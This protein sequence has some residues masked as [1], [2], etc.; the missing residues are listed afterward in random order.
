MIL[1][2]YVMCRGKKKKVEDLSPTSGYKVDVKCSECEKVRSVHYRS[3]C[4]AG[5]TICQKC[6]AKIKMGKTLPIGKEFNRLTV[7]KPSKKSGY[8]IFLCKCGNVKE[9]DNNNVIIGHTTSCGCLR[10][11]NM[12]K[13]GFHPIGEEHWHWKG[14]KSG[15]RYTAMQRKE[16]KDWR[17]VVFERDNYTC[18]KCNQV[19]YDIRAHHIH[20][21][22]DYLELR[23][24][25]GNGITLCNTC[26]K[27]FH[28]KHGN[29]TN[30][31]Q[32]D[33]FLES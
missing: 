33:V 6:S 14:G 1:T 8:T 5:H 4:T 31:A 29:K 19:G 15:E 20:N 27:E 9:V 2:E 30:K 23:I 11:E 28:N 18:Q 21:Y 17:V 24:D 13:N 12:R 16:Y 32:L 22:A 26:H 3:I 7:I 25:V 10:A